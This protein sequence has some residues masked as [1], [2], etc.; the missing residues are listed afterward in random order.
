MPKYS[1]IGNVHPRTSS[2]YKDSAKTRHKK[3]TQI[4]SSTNRMSG[5]Q[6]S[7]YRHTRYLLASLT[8]LGVSILLDLDVRCWSVC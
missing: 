6:G 5:Q 8:P 2:K 7:L 3:E 4:S 1:H